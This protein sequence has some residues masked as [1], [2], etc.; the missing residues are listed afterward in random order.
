MINLFSESVIPINLENKNSNYFGY[1]C[2]CDFGEN[3]EN[4]NYV[5]NY[6]HDEE[7]KYFNKLKFE[8]RIKSY[9]MG[10]YSAKI[11][12][13]SYIKET[14]LRKICILN[15][16]FNHPVV[17]TNY[18]ENV[19]VS[20]SHSKNISYS[21]SFSEK[22]PMGIDIEYIRYDNDKVLERYTKENELNIL[23]KLSLEYSQGLYLLWTAKESL[24]K[25]LKIGFLSP[26]SIF[27]VNELKDMG[28]FILCDYKNFPMFSSKCFIK[29]DY[30]ISITYPNKLEFKSFMF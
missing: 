29:K 14:D 22:C 9:L 27:E 17:I 21:L 25:A 12:I 5:E 15:G 24:S 19:Q 2:R 10:R 6:L 28:S 30:I 16:I 20:I 4:L 13:S 18:N 26:I 11:A 23:N 3:N 1:I 8:K 7:L